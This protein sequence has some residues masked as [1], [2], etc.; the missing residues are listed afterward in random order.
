MH[1][2]AGVIQK[3]KSVL[4]NTYHVIDIFDHYSY[5]SH[6]YVD[7]PLLSVQVTDVP[8][9]GKRMGRGGESRMPK[10]RKGLFTRCFLL[11][12]HHVNAGDPSFAPRNTKKLPL[13]KDLHTVPGK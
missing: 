8:L 3:K 13:T 6:V 5:S 2:V 10:R 12:A 11:L 4:F 9:D 1:I 7:N